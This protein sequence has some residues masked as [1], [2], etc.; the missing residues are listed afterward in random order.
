MGFLSG[1]ETYFHGVK[2]PGAGGTGPGS[3]AHDMWRDHAPGFDVVANVT[4]SANYYARAAV[5]IIER[6]N[7]SRALFLYL[8]CVTT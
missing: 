2:G 4:Y 6:R 5:E 1:E 8:P 3:G 7:T